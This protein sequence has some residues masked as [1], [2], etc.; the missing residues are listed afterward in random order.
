[1]TIGLLRGSVILGEDLPSRT[2][3][4]QSGL[5]HRDR[6]RVEETLRDLE[7]QRRSSRIDKDQCQFDQVSLCQYPVAFRMK[8]TAIMDMNP[9]NRPRIIAMFIYGFL[10]LNRSLDRQ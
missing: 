10:S 5:V 9:G 7:T 8:Y 6:D 2:P 4:Q 3:V 1:M